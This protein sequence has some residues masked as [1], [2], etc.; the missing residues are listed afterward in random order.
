MAPSH[1]S[2]PSP[3]LTRS[4]AKANLAY[5][6]ER[7][8]GAPRNGDIELSLIRAGCDTVENIAS[9]SKDDVDR[10]SF[11]QTDSAGITTLVP[12]Q[13][14]RRGQLRA[15]V[16]YI[17]H[18]RHTDTF[19]SYTT[20]DQDAFDV[21]RTSIYYN[22]DMPSAPNP[23]VP[24]S[25]QRSTIL[26][27]F[28][29][30][31]KRD[32]SHYQV[33]K[34]DK[35]WDSWRRSTLAT[36]RSHAC[37]E[38]FDPN[39]RP[40]TA[41]ELAVFTEKQ[42]F[43]Y[44]VFEEKLKT[45]MGKYF[46]RIHES[47]FDAQSIFEQLQIHA[48]AST[49]A[50]LDN[51]DLLSYIT[52]TKLHDSKWRGTSHSF[53]LHWCDQVRTYEDM[54]PPVDHFTGNLKMAMLQNAVSGITELHQV[55]VQSAHDVAHGNS[56]LSYEQ[57][58]TLLLSTASTYDARKGLARSRPSRL[59]HETDLDPAPTLSAN[60]HTIDDTNDDIFYDIDTDLATLEI[61][62]TRQ[63]ARRPASN[64]RFQPKMSRDK[65]QSLSPAEQSCWD[66]LS[67][68]AKATILGI[69]TPPPPRT[70]RQLDL[71][72]ISAADYL[73]IVST[74]QSHSGT[75]PPALIRDSITESASTLTT[76]PVPDLL[77]CAT[78]QTPTPGDLRRGL[79]SQPPPPNS[80]EITINGK[81]YRCISMHERFSYSISNHSASRHGSLVDRGANG[82]LAG[83][84]VRIISKDACPRLVDVSGIDSH[85]INNL[86]IVTVG[87]V[88]PSQ[89]GPVIAVMHQYAY[90]G[91]GKTI[92][93][94]GQLEA[95]KNDVNDK[96]L[97]VQGGLQRI[98]TNDGYVHPLTIRN[99][100]PYVTI[101]PFTDDEWNTLPHVIWTS[102]VEWDPSILDCNI[103][104]EDT[105]YD[106]VSDLEGGLIHSPFDEFGRYSY[107]SAEL[108]F[109]DPG[110]SMPAIE[111]VTDEVVIEHDTQQVIF[112]HE[113][114]IHSNSHTTKR[115]PP[116]YES[117]R[118]FF[119]HTTA[120]IVKKTF[121]ATTQ[122]A[123][124]TMGGAHMKKTYRSPFPAL[125][126][127]RRQE[128]V[129]TDTVYSDEPAI[130]N[131]CTAAQI[132]IG[133]DS[134][135]ADV[136]PL[137]TEKQFVN[138]LEDNIR[139]RGAMD[140]LISDR[141]QVEISN[142][143]HDILRAYHIDDWQSEPHYQHQNMAERRWGVIKAMV[144]LLLNR[145]G[146]PAYAWFLALLYVCCVLNHTAI[147]SLDWRT[148]L[149]KLTG[150][151]PDISPIIMYQ[152]WEPVYYKTHD[153]SFPSDSTEQSGRFVGIAEHVGHTMTFKVLT[154][155]TQKVIYRSRIRSALKQSEANLRLDP[156]KD[157]LQS[158]RAHDQD[159]ATLPTFDPSSLIGRTFLK[160]PEEDGQRF[161]ARIL[162]NIAQTSEDTSNHPDHIK[163]RCSVNDDEY[164]E[165][166]S[167]NEIIDHIEKDETD[168]G[169]WRF[170]SITGHQ[171]PLSQLDANYK[172]SRYNVLVNWE[173]GEC[174]YEPLNMIAADDPV[175]CAAY[176]K[177]H[178]LLNED[179]WRRFKRIAKRQTKLIR[180]VKQA[181]LRSVRT[182]PIYKYGFLVPRNHA[183][184]VEIDLRNG[185]TRWQSAEMTEATQLGDYNTFI[186]K[187]KGA[188]VP[189]GYKKIRC[190]F[191][192]DVKHDGRHKARLVAGGHL[193]ETPVGSVYS[194]VVS[195]KGLRLVTFLAE[196][197]GLLLWSTDIGNAYLEATTKEKVCII[198]GPEFGPMEGHLLLIHKAL[199]GLRSSGLRWHERF[200]DTLRSM[201]F[202][203]SKAE[204]DIWMRPNGNVYEYIASYV[205]DL[206]IA[207]KDPA[208]IIDTLEKTYGYKLKGTGP[209]EYHL[210]CDYFRDDDGTLCFA[211][212]RY[213][214]KM[215]DS[216]FQLFGEKPKPYTSPLEKGDHPELDTSDELGEVD[217]KKYQSLIGALQWAVTVGRIDI[218]TAVMT[219]SSYRVN[220]RIGHSTVFVASM[221]TSPR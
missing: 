116:D 75:S 110:E 161:R 196:L 189:P 102:D 33:F 178:G 47:D 26:D 64:P 204:D 165:V 96:S 213:I 203:P 137:K 174:T 7:V 140:K 72:D 107:R 139:K 127:H 53:I 57:Y 92:H 1:P 159:T 143:V 208:S 157:T 48:R 43:I 195:L 119:L 89:R 13:A 122:Y 164:E 37:E 94:C 207:A 197:N 62:E 38:V 131:G 123:R 81:R 2:L 136:Y 27:D 105:W 97:H 68:K 15:L 23:P 124:T 130:D 111:D 82:G 135:V 151:T 39:Y 138:T 86:P 52:T 65:W 28:R 103:Q 6:I 18:L 126:V 40:T 186:D 176:A 83:S 179:G 201:G 169:F 212:K 211:P 190:H 183:Q 63:P 145:T 12:L 36:A 108:H 172:G 188:A 101:R 16:A 45:D 88:V 214:D 155:D 217:I 61:N 78:R 99:G 34:E 181:K 19:V 70:P 85:Q 25:A 149:E 114:R 79:G 42:K 4:S 146:A 162:E 21:Y 69:G 87:G 51:A 167:Y 147:E 90:M 153:P 129:A 210:G 209:I 9:M 148:P 141:A 20:I 118:P 142:R 31:I 180:L 98:T 109:F 144:N 117:L 133:R 177:E 113:H 206:C 24:R 134:M 104:D 152:F 171:G 221:D 215:I 202:L 32:K 150:T 60:V 160:P 3:P 14:G 59:V 166:L 46:V 58:K 199:Y 50:S 115:K 56:P 74:H 219:M 156:I 8:L 17:R 187:G 73:R 198:A 216:Y 29:K 125:N 91:E 200:A 175:T 193:T 41:D 80:D 22:P 55:K 158:A 84:D 71:H 191:V 112:A 49:Q 170:K 154:D 194:S 173:S 132:F 220:P 30:G 5:I 10:L 67:A 95:Y 168:F 192:Y 218:T 184:A 44:S 76:P 106:A 205:D 93:S 121:L 163:F 66:Q 120:D 100:L 54:I 185:N 128:P 11:S 182:V 77:A 35:Q